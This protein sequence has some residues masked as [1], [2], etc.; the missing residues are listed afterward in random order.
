[1]VKS[2]LDDLDLVSLTR[3]ATLAALHPE[4]LR[5]AT[6][7]GRLR[8]VRVEGTSQDERVFRRADILAFVAHRAR[9][10]LAK[11]LAKRLNPRATV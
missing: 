2:D 4:T 1:M 6:R 8:C 5:D 7:A 9:R 10:P 11:K 3:A